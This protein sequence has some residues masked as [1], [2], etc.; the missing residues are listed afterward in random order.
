M[1]SDGEIAASRASSWP[2]EISQALA[3]CSPRLTRWYPHTPSPPAARPKGAADTSLKRVNFFTRD[4]GRFE[5]LESIGGCE[6]AGTD[7]KHVDALDLEDVRQIAHGLQL[8]DHHAH[9]RLG[10]GDLDLEP[11]DGHGIVAVAV[12]FDQ[13]PL[14]AA[15]KFVEALVS[16]ATTNVQTITDPDR[17]RP[18]DMPLL[19]GDPTRLRQ[20]TGWSASVPIPQMLQDTLDWWRAEVRQG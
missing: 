11:V 10:I 4:S 12:F 2:C 19:Q 9:Q 6:I 18:S 5:G 16:L 20:A 1:G 8:F 7:E 17:L 15:V 13:E 3:R 14:A